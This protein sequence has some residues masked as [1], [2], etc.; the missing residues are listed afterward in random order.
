MMSHYHGSIIS[1]WRQQAAQ[2]TTATKTR[3][4]KEQWFVVRNNKFACAAHFFVIS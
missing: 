4:A 3:I 2:A 1:G